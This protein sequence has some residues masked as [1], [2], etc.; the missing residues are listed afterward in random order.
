VNANL[1]ARMSFAEL[2]KSGEKGVD[3]AFIDAEGEFAT[4]EALEVE[5]PFFDFVAEVEEAIGVFAEEL[6]GVREANRAGSTDEERLA[7]RVFELADSQADGGLSTVKTLGGAREAAFA[8]NGKKN[9][10]FG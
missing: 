4:L 7:E 6:A 8:G 2:G 5:E 3:G 1:Y 9:L 10:K